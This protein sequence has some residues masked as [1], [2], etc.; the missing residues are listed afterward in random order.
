MARQ[1]SQ[2]PSDRLALPTVPRA[3]P[4]LRVLALLDPRVA[5]AARVA[6]AL[7]YKALLAALPDPR[8]R[9]VLLALPREKRVLQARLEARLVRLVLRA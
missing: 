7:V 3:Q 9:L 8:D 2:V 5:R 6:R 4:V 1:V